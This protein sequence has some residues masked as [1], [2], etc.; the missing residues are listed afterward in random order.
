MGLLTLTLA[1]SAAPLLG[2]LRRPDMRPALRVLRALL[3][4][5]PWVSY[6]FLRPWQQ[7]WGAAPDE[8][9]QPLPGDDQVHHPVY[10]TTRAIT[11]NARPEEIWPWLA[12]M[13][14]H[15]YGRAGW[16]AVDLL[17]NDGRPSA[18][19][20]IPEFQH[21]KVGDRVGE[22]GFR[23]VALDPPY[24]LVL[25]YHYDRVSWVVKQGIW[26][27]FGHCSWAFVLQPLD[28]HRTRLIERGRL[29][30][31]PTL[32]T[33]PFYLLFC[34]GGDFV[35]QR[36]QLRNIKRRVEHAAWPSGGGAQETT[37]PPTRLGQKERS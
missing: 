22:E 28:E 34:Q 10:E 12:Q 7:R 31:K 33:F 4:A 30:F 32:T 36:T 27:L 21:P 3:A 9:H 15:G 16:Y 24:A 18:E 19:R 37:W 2:V 17:D 35:M 29:A 13:G 5:A 1:G 6:L 20:I 25:A 11:I 8:I 26:P 14:Y 23:I